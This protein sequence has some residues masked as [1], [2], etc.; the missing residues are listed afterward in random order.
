M[1]RT[2]TIHA[3]EVAEAADGRSY[4]ELAESASAA[5]ETSDYRTAHVL[6]MAAALVASTD[7]ELDAALTG[8]GWALERAAVYQPDPLPHVPEVRGMLPPTVLDWSVP[9]YRVDSRGRHVAGPLYG[10]APAGA[11]WTRP[12]ARPPL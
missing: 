9:V 5:V 12:T 3:G 7:S 11:S 4:A 1:I 2:I 8:A 6:C 10:P